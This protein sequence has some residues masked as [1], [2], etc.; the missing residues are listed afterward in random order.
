ML[1]VTPCAPCGAAASIVNV[2]VSEVEFTTF[3]ALT[4]TPVPL[5]DTVVAP[6]TKF[7]PVN[8]TGTAAPW[9]PNE[10][11]M[12]DNVGTAFTVKPSGSV[13]VT[14]LGSVTVTS[15]A[16]VD[17]LPAIVIEIETLVAVAELMDACT[18]VP[19]NVTPV[20]PARFAPVMV[21]GSP[22]V[23]CSPEFGAIAV[24]TGPEVSVKVPAA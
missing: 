16:P 19:L 13:A 5:S 15:R 24:T 21:A 3:T 4:T 20:A 11:L 6:V 18:P 7:A 2:A 10:G 1:T 17:A 23:P 22:V 12:A 14:P 8:V 9:L